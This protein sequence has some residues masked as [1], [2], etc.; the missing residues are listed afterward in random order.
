MAIGFFSLLLVS[1]FITQ[2]DIEEV[3]QHCSHTFSQQEIVSLYERFCQLDHSGG[4]F[5]FVDEFLSVPEFAPNPLSLRLRIQQRIKSAEL[6]MLT[7]EQ[8][9]E[10]L[11]FTPFIPLMSPLLMAHLLMQ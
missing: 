4:G 3:Q 6:R 10:L 5:I 1:L 9:N 11:N 8:E 2:Y 7:E